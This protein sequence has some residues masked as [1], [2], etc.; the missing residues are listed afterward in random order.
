MPETLYCQ[1]VTSKRDYKILL[2]KSLSNYSPSSSCIIPLAVVPQLSSPP[3]PSVHLPS[4]LTVRD[5]PQ[6]HSAKD[7]TPQSNII[8]VIANDY[9][10]SQYFMLVY[11]PSRE[12][13]DK[14]SIQFDR[15]IFVSEIATVTTFGNGPN[16]NA[17]DNKNYSH[18][19][20]CVLCVYRTR[21]RHRTSVYF[22]RII[23]I[24][25]RT[26]SVLNITIFVQLPL[27][28]NVRAG[29][30]VRHS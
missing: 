20:K 12:T 24:K 5:Q 26:P 19:K 1:K 10:Q 11:C 3:P 27:V 22:D 28:E 4:L 30:R 7:V 13:L 9:F 17:S 21:M 29:L 2:C 15:S 14:K 8:V 16:T 6:V 23:S 18:R 25:S